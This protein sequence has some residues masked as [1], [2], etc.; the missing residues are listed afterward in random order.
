MSIV[1]VTLNPAVDVS[2]SVERIEPEHKLRC[3]E[4]R[5]DPGG[6]GVNVA[7]VVR[8]FGGDVLA[9][10]PAGGAIGALLNATLAAEQ[11]PTRSIPIA[12]TTR[13]S[14][15]VAERESGREFRFVLP[16]PHLDA[17]VFQTLLTALKTAAAPAFVVLS[18]SLPPGAPVDAYAQL[19]RI[20]ADRGAKVALDASGAAL[21]EALAC[22]VYLVKPSV[23][24]LEEFCGRPLPNLDSIVGA[25]NSLIDSKR[26]EIV[27]VTMGARGALLVTLAQTLWADALPV[28]VV[29]TVGAGDSF[30]GA[31]VYRLDRGDN[32]ADAFRLGVAAATASLLVAGTQL[33]DPET[34]LSLVESVRLQELPCDAGRAA[35]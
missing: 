7:R 24:E 26:A 21:K 27:I 17:T 13:E 30:L 20:A 10:Y 32:I 22:G 35:P 28:A 3:S 29:G 9:L 15:T 33:C 16:G 11:V 25:A 12:G 1:T 19:A 34:V 4:E 23:R 14:F 31:M 18:G 8:R 5:R 2:T 6:G